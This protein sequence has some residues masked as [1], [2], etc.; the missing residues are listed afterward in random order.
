MEN[1]LLKNFHSH[2]F[3]PAITPTPEPGFR[4]A[5]PQKNRAAG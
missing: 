3:L 1:V 2:N 5:F 4:L